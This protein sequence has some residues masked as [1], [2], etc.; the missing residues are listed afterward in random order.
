MCWLVASSHARCT[1][2]QERDAAT[3]ASHAAT[4]EAAAHAATAARLRA[5]AEAAARHARLESERFAASVRAAEQR[6]RLAASSRRRSGTDTDAAEVPLQ[7]IASMVDTTL[8]VSSP[9]H[10]PPSGARHHFA[11]SAVDTPSLR[12]GGRSAT[13]AGG[14]A[15][16]GGVAL[17]SVLE[18]DEEE[19]VGGTSDGNVAGGVEGSDEGD[20]DAS[21]ADEAKVGQPAIHNRKR[22]QRQSSN[23]GDTP[24]AAAGAPP[25]EDGGDSGTTSSSGDVNADGASALPPGSTTGGQGSGGEESSA[26]IDAGT[27]GD[28]TGDGASG[29]EAP[30]GADGGTPTPDGGTVTGDGGGSGNGDSEA[31]NGFQAPTHAPVPKKKKKGGC[32]VM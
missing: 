8:A 15:S 21:M 19:G 22:K 16:L 13:T 25:A 2:H 24:A 26:G 7:E 12:G 20:G 14:Q 32:V 28:D 17:V 3:A 6:E 11:P 23:P 27:Q 10:S 18:E 5:E 30:S 29:G 9:G 31:S 1:G 4:R